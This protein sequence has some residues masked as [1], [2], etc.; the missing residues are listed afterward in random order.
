MEIRPATN[1]PGMFYLIWNDSGVEGGPRFTKIET[2]DGKPSQDAILMNGMQHVETLHIQA[3]AVTSFFNAAI[4]AGVPVCAEVQVQGTEG[5]TTHQF[6][7]RVTTT[8]RVGMKA[9]IKTCYV[10]GK[11]HQGNEFTIASEPR[12][13]C[14]TWVVAL[15][16]KDGSRFSSAYD[17][18]MLEITD[19]G[20]A[21]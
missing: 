3:D 8:P 9:Q 18:S 16:N 13:L 15:N 21:A 17:L 12:E 2:V 14:G 10:E 11:L 7:G 19:L 6:T 1:Q 4:D 20:V 5:K